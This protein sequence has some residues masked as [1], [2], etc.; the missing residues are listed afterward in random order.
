MTC[1]F[2]VTY[3]LCVLCALCFLCLARTAQT[4]R[5]ASYPSRSKYTFTF[6]PIHLSRK[7]PRIQIEV[8]GRVATDKFVRD[9][10]GPVVA[11]IY[12]V[13]GGKKRKLYAK[14]LEEDGLFF[15]DIS[16]Y[17]HRG[18]GHY[19][20]AVEAN[21]GQHNHT[22]V[23]YID[24]LTLHLRP[25][26]DGLGII[27]G[28]VRALTRGRVIENSPDQYVEP[29]AKPVGFKRRDPHLSEY[30]ARVW[31]YA[32]KKKRF[33]PGRWWWDK[34]AIEDELKRKHSPAAELSGKAGRST[35]AT[36]ERLYSSGSLKLQNVKLY[37]D[38]NRY[39]IE[40]SWEEESSQSVVTFTAKKCSAEKRIFSRKLDINTPVVEMGI[41]YAKNRKMAFLYLIEATTFGITEVW[42]IEKNSLAPVHLLT[43]IAA[44]TKALDRGLLT[45][46]ALAR[47]VFRKRPASV[48]QDKV[49]QRL[50]RYDSRSQR[51]HPGKWRAI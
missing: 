44:H 49:Y 39:N 33:R 17:R 27:Y 9:L 38:H 12:S 26:L 2:R 3:V 14:T 15:V 31:T 43:T 5:I 48:P 51:F 36:A 41:A 6:H 46:V 18:S 4:Q 34:K 7:Y 13:Q 22:Q 28:D 21:G 19:L 50:W 8:K 32:P 30:L 25:L 37:S 35:F 16:L 10:I 11:S 29:D 23:Y 1:T 20:L 40:I 45:E 42:R 47:Y 24:P